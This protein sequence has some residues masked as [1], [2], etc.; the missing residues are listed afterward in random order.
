MQK[1]NMIDTVCIVYVC[2]GVARMYAIPCVWQALSVGRSARSYR[3]P[4]SAYLTL[5]LERAIAVVLLSV[6]LSVCPSAKR[7]LLTK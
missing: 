4:F 7:V 2:V 3:N 6:C 1:I 5:L